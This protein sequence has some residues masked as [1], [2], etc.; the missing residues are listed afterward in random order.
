[1]TKP[2][3]PPDVLKYFQTQGGGTAAQFQTYLSEHLAPA[4][5]RLGIAGQP[6]VAVLPIHALAT[7]GFTPV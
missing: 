5:G 1:M 2:K 4:F 6:A 3:L 7:P